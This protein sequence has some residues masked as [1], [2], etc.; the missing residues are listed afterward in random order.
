[1]D[2]CLPVPEEVWLAYGGD[3]Q[4]YISLMAQ[5]VP[6]IAADRLEKIVRAERGKLAMDDAP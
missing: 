1:M 5:L 3:R 4:R 2:T 6:P